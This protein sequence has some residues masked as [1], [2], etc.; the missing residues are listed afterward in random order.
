[1]QEAQDG[2]I[3]VFDTDCVLCSGA[4]AFILGHER[5]RSLRFVGAWSDTGLALAARHGFTRADLNETF[6]VITAADALARSDAALAVAGHLRAPWRWL[7]VL[8]VVPRPVRDAAYGLVARHRYRWFGQRRN[9]V[10]VPAAERARFVG[11]AG[12]GPNR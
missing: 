5:D 12:S 11:L 6:L 3:M 9:C 10:V 8:R 1:M 4:V 7:T 2:P